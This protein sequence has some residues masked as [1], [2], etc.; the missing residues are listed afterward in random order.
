MRSQIFPGQEIRTRH[1]LLGN[2]LGPGR[3]RETMAQTFLQR[4]HG[5]G[6]GTP[7]NRYFGALSTRQA[8]MGRP[9]RPGG[10]YGGTPQRMT[11]R[12][13]LSVLVDNDARRRKAL[14]GE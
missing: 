12:G 4:H 9:G 3:G 7:L 8:G 13:L 10:I 11:V 1:P 14:G 5:G 6:G 2:P